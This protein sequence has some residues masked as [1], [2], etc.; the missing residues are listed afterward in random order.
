LLNDEGGPYGS[1]D[2]RS[3]GEWTAR[4]GG[5][6]NWEFPND[7][8]AIIK[9]PDIILDLGFFMSDEWESG[10]MSLQHWAAV[11]GEA[12]YKADPVGNGPWTYV[13]HSVNQEFLHKRVE[14]H[15]RRTPEFHERHILLVQEAATRMAALLAKEVDIIP[16]IRN[17]RQTITA[18][19]FKT[20]LSTFPSV[21][22]GIGMIYYRPEAYCPQ[23]GEKT[24]AGQPCGPSKGYDPNDPLRKPEVRLAL[25]H[26]LDRNSMNTAFYQG[27]GFP[28]VDYFPPWRS[29]FLDSWAPHPGPNGKTGKAGGYPYNYDV[30]KAKQLL[31]QGGFPNGFNTI[32]NCLRSHN[33]IPEWPDICEKIKQDF[34][35]IGVN[36]ELEMVNAFGE[37]RNLAY[38]RNRGNWMWSASPSLDPVCHAVE[39]SLIWEL[40]NGY[41]EHEDASAFYN[42][43]L[44][45]TTFAARDKISQDFG[46]IWVQK[47]FSIPMFWVTAEVAFNPAVVAEY[48]VNML[49]MGPVRYHEYT[50]AVTK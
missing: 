38:Q 45:T 14:N 23:G 12:G 29:D 3:P 41:R 17:Q 30:A 47:A 16:L 13:K 44:V 39:F 4:M 20:E 2:T 25:N 8:T 27:N 7:Q 33:V 5:A 10:V 46:T 24:K 19:G 15:Y 11:G 22:Q 9:A 36:A 18:Q 49:H 32:L 26:A 34:A 31:A 6:D 21:H 50:K 1:K 28:S 42:K 35:A 37:F 40:G 48:K 43:C